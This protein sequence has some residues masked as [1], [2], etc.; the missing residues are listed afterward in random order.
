MSHLSPQ[1]SYAM[2]E[3]QLSLILLLPIIF[4]I[5]LLLTSCL[6][7]GEVIS[8]PDEFKHVYE[9]DE[10]KLLHAVAHVFSDKGFGS[11]A[12]NQEKN[13]VE[14]G[15]LIQNDWRTKSIARVKKINWKE[16]ELVLS[17][18]SEKKTSK[19]WEMR[20]LLGKKQYDTFFDAIE[21]Q[22]YQEMYKV[23]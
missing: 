12:I 10:N 18:I 9:A 2:N 16:C 5:G 7:E 14:S 22:L 6:E 21:L 4:S 3:R 13:Q 11:V 19:G 15:Y 23:K 1:L 17:V 8:Q 20:R